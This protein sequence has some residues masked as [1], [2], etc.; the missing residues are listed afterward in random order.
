M[1]KIWIFLKLFSPRHKK[2][3]KDHC[4]MGLL[5]DFFHPV[6]NSKQTFFFDLGILMTSPSFQRVFLDDFQ[7]A[8]SGNRSLRISLTL[9]S[10]DHGD[11]YR[12]VVE[13]ATLVEFNSDAMLW[14]R[15]TVSRLHKKADIFMLRC[16]VIESLFNRRVV[17]IDAVTIQ[18]RCW[19]N[20][21][22]P[23]SIPSDFFGSEL[24]K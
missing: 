2:V 8:P 23:K 13:T 22:G 5:L 16:R 19:P 7:G 12:C 18:Y 14:S 10:S 1:K 21:P 6:R 4:R 15:A 17:S 20:L 11:R 9:V 3:L 24:R